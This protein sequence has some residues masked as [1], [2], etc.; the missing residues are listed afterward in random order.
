[1]TRGMN[2]ETHELIAE[3]R[4][5]MRVGFGQVNGRLDTVNGRL[6]KSEIA[7]AVIQFAV[8]TVGG[9]LAYAGMQIVVARLTG[10]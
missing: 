10:Q 8:L 7:I 1:M 3:L 9:G 5:E 6:R 4:A 2:G